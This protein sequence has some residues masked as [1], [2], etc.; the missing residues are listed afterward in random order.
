MNNI[1]VLFSSNDMTWETPIDLFNKLNAEFNFNLDVCALP[2]TAKCSNYFTPDIDGLKQDWNGVCWMNPPYGRELGVWIEKAYNESLKNA[3]VVCL[4]PARTD[5]KYWQN[6][7]MKASEIRFIKGRLKFGNSKNSA[8]FP[9]AI[10][11]FNKNKKSKIIKPFISKNYNLE[12][13]IFNN[14]YIG[15]T[16]I[17]EL[18][19]HVYDIWKE[20]IKKQYDIQ[21]FFNIPIQIIDSRWLCFQLFLNDFPKIIGYN[22]ELLMSNSLELCNTLP[23][24]IPDY[25]RVYSI[26]TCILKKKEN[27]NLI[28][29]IRRI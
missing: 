10:V 18:N 14:G 23:Y 8:P 1:K 12:R 11:I 21:M 24:T 17:N 22:E 19:K 13:N 15:Y 16:Y 25:S 2:Q 27:N 28:S 26:N 4:I 29:V 9:S 7:C 5:T 20:M 3:I 6:F